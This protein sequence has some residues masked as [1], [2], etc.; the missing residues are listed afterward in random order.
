MSI[1]VAG[2]EDGRPL[3]SVE[4]LDEGSEEWRTD[5][6]LPLSILWSQMVEDQKGGV[7]LIGGSSDFNSSM[8]T[9]FHLPHGGQCDSYPQMSLFIRFA[10][11]IKRIP[12]FQLLGNPSQF[13]YCF[14]LLNIS[15]CVF[16]HSD[17][18]FSLD[19]RIFYIFMDL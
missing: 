13:Q 9:L 19:L 11:I 8:D 6:N 1:I 16:D 14:L 15:C 12:T 10:I 17:K 3:S 4:I 7:I 18:T 5:P 2:G